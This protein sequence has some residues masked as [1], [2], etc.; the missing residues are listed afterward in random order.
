MKKIEIQVEDCK[1]CPLRS[2]YCSTHR[3]YMD[4]CPREECC[5]HP[6]VPMGGSYILLYDSAMKHREDY[7]S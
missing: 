6:L 7:K 5:K 1:S 3:D 2:P 4:F